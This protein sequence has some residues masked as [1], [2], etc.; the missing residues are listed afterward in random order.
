MSTSTPTLTE[1]TF[2]IRAE[3][4]RPRSYRPEDN[5]FPMLI[6]DVTHRCNMACGNCYI[7]NRH[8]ADMD[9]GW[10]RAILGRLPRRVQV[11]IAG[12]EATVRKDLPELVGMIRQIG[13]I[14]IVLTN[15]LKLAE[16]AYVRELRRAGMRTCY[17][18]LNGGFDDDAYEE[19][20]GLRCAAQKRAALENLLAHNVFVNTGTIL[21]RG[22]NEAVAGPVLQRLRASGLPAILKLRS[23]GAIGRY[24]ER[25]TFRLPQML[26]IVRER[27][28]IDAEARISRAGSGAEMRVGRVQIQLTQW[29]DMGSERR[30]RITPAG[31]IEPF[32]EHVLANEGGY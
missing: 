9:A 21:V 22:V 11:R 25:E 29:P 15:G 24:M 20:D 18:S 27:L 7:P 26:E 14:P 1:P 13:H 3:A 23:I 10:L 5:P 6:A 19:I 16:R 31:A 32:F 2:P 28:G 8:I 4:P 17:L 12:A 30:G